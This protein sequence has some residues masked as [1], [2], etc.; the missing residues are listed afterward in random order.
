MV[1]DSEIRFRYCFIYLGGKN[2]QIAQLVQLA[3]IFS[4]FF[5][6]ASMTF[7]QQHFRPKTSTFVNFV[8]FHLTILTLQHQAKLLVEDSRTLEDYKQR[9]LQSQKEL[10]GSFSFS[11]SQRG[12]ELWSKREKQNKPNTF[13]TFSISL[14]LQD[15]FRICIMYPIL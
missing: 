15:Q 2:L 13:I 5:L 3:D 12:R 4:S 11:Q 9:S 7:W 8:S 10:L 6:A 1:P 14:S